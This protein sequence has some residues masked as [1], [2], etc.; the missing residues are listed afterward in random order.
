MSTGPQVRSVSEG[1][2]SSQIFPGEKGQVRI[3]RGSWEMHQHILREANRGGGGR[4][5]AGPGGTPTWTRV[6]KEPSAELP[7]AST[8]PWPDVHCDWRAATGVNPWSLEW[9][10]LPE[11]KEGP[12][13]TCEPRGSRSQEAKTPRQDAGDNWSRGADSNS[14]SGRSHSTPHTLPYEG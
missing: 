5:I 10:V 11:I 7:S 3:R 8:Q 4:T 6:K 9:C 1:T 13:A 14:G 2:W 12:M